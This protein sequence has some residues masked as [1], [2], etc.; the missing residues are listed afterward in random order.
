MSEYIEIDADLGDD[1]II[2]VQT[3]LRLTPDGVEETYHSTTA[4][5]EGSPI[6]QALS[7]IMGIESLTMRN[8]E[9]TIT[10]HP[11]ADWHAV[12][13]EVTAALKDFFL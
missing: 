1:G 7:S 10:T 8:G 11:G 5:E 6:A 3:N 12:I 2:L 9:M 13:A 4:I